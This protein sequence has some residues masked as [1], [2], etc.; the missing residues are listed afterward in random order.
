[1][2]YRFSF[3]PALAVCVLLA[4]C[5][6]PPRQNAPAP[7]A[8]P[9]ASPQTRSSPEIEAAVAAIAGT[10]DFAR[11]LGA[12][13]YVG[14]HLAYDALQ[15]SEQFSR[16]AATLFRD[17]TLD[18][19]SD[20][21]LAELALFRALGYPSRLVLT[22]NAKWVA[23]YR[24]N[25][26]ALPNGHSFIEVLVQGR[27]RLV[28]PTQFVIYDDYDPN[29]LYLPGNE[30][31]LARASDFAE[32]GLTSTEA[33]NARLRQAAEA[34]TGIYVNPD[35][36]GRWKVDFDYPTAFANLGQIFLEKKREALGLRL[37]RK[38]L[39]LKP[40]N[41]PALLALGEHSLGHGQQSEATQF[42]RRALAAD[43]R[44]ERAAAGLRQAVANRPEAAAKTP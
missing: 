32:V 42:F 36:P 39:A 17:R 2:R 31:F 7:S 16:D 18:G 12:I 26:L 8:A 38:A 6:A 33:A 41:L 34:F 43:P 10:D 13:R 23:R 14:E 40:D 21:A 44:N 30:I 15:S 9:L 1:M 4:A 37:L 35:L 11:L 22:F 27:W 25:K 20:F 29:A 3:L 28:D 24:Q 19:C 5:A